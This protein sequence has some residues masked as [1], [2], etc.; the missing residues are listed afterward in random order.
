MSNK[1]KQKNQQK[2]QQFNNSVQ[3]VSTQQEKPTVKVVSE[4]LTTEE[5]AALL[6]ES[7]FEMETYVNE[8]KEKA[9]AYFNEQK[10]KADKYYS[11]KLEEADGLKEKAED[12][13]QKEVDKAVK[14]KKK[15]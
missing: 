3:H 2:N 5:G 7:L 13:I 1:N 4:I 12:S 14:Q 15:K 10:E 11:E 9:D 6:Q 8:Q